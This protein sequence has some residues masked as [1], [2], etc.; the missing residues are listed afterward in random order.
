MNL[1]ERWA[2]LLDGLRADGRY[3]ELTPPAGIDFASN[4]YLGYGTRPLLRDNASLPRSGLASRLL[5]GHHPVWEQVE[6]ALARWHGAEA[7]LVMNSG[8]AANEGL[9]STVVTAADWVASDQMNHASIIDG[10][11][12]SRAERFVFRHNDLGHLESGLRE[13]AGTRSSGRQLFIVTEALF[14]MDGDRAPLKD[15]TA[16][17]ERYGAHLIVDEAHA[18]GC[19]GP[20]GSGCTDAAGLRGKVL[21]SVHT[22]GKAL[23]VVGAYVCGSAQ[24]R[25]VLVNRCRHFIYTT[26]LPPAVGGWWLEALDRVRADEIGRRRLHEAGAFFSAELARH[27]IP[28]AGHHYI[29]PVLLRSDARAVKASSRL[30]AAGWDMRAIRPP[31]VPPGT[32]RLRIALHADHDRATLAAAAAALAEVVRQPP[33]D[34]P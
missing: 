24:L 33:G 17:T 26:A 10:L 19:F 15:M 23:G 1:T 11:R 7:A 4:D 25:E 22:G 29:L 8:Y 5:R 32:S 34:L 14:G 28:A 9:L 20:A 21:A 16:L 18:T 6:D 2:A 31:S 27:G 12:L 3:R 30:R 13:A